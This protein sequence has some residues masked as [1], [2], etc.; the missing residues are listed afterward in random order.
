MTSDTEKGDTAVSPEVLEVFEVEKSASSEAVSTIV[1]GTGH[2]GGSQSGATTSA[3]TAEPQN[4]NLWREL[5]N[6]IGAG[7]NG[8]A[9][10]RI[11][12]ALEQQ[13]MSLEQ[14]LAYRKRFPQS[15][16]ARSRVAVLIATA[17]TLRQQIA[18]VEPN[19]QDRIPEG[20]E[21]GLS[22]NAKE[23]KK[24]PCSKCGGMSWIVGPKG[25]IR[26]DCVRGTTRARTKPESPE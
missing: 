22:V 10:T 1:E 26:C 5:Q 8:N 18:A 23:S 24:A 12:A 25:A 17:K 15:A 19:E 2:A 3:P 11:A 7:I 13:G 16:N 14:L 9:R 4:A 20:R 21:Y 6:E